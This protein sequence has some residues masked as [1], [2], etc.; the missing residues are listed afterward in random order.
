MR[1]VL[2]DLATSHSLASARSHL[3]PSMEIDSF[4]GIDELRETAARFSVLPG[5]K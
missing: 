5:L 2:T 1:R 4:L 3:M